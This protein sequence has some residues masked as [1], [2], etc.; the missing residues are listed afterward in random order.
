MDIETTGG[1]AGNHR[2]TEVAIIHHDGNKVTRRYQTLVNPQQLIPP[3]IMQLTGIS[4]EMV[5]DAPPFEEVAEEIYS[6]LHDRIFVAH[7]V[8]FDHSF[9][10]KMLEEAGYR[11]Q[12]QRLCTVRLSRKILP[13]FK[14]Y[15]LGNICCDIGIDITDRHRAMG[16]AEATAILFGKL[17]EADGEG[18]VDEML[19]RH[20]GHQPLPPHVDPEFIRQLPRTHGVYQFLGKKGELL[21]VGKARSIRHRVRNHFNFADHDGHEN[22]LREAIYG[23]EYIETGNE[24]V[25]LLLEN[26]LIK[27][28]QPPFNK[29]QKFWT[30]NYC[31]FR[32]KGQDGI[33]HLGIE[34]YKQSLQPLRVFPNF[35]MAREFLKELQETH[36][37]CARYCHLQSAQGKCYGVEDGTCIGIC[38]DKRKKS[39]YNKRVDLAVED[40]RQGMGTFLISGKGRR[41]EEHSVIL[42]ENGHYLGFGFVPVDTNLSEFE[43][44]REHIE[45]RPDTPDIQYLLMRYIDKHPDCRLFPGKVSA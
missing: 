19:K 42:V 44:V 39:T 13:G 24:L 25:A 36:G 22:A 21:Y 3:F 7:N 4:N 38:L 41:P 43:K 1:I 27:R 5:A 12:V 33:W 28:K 40:I 6:L 32:Y 34:R 35:L 14:S 45:W 17:L 29:A 30:R 11:L 23:I 10:R 18:W 37:L 16:D 31:L 15:S 2:I 8:G 26:D 9:V 20:R